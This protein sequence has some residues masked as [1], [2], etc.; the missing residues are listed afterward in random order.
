MTE[1]SVIRSRL[2]R[3]FDAHR[4]VFWHDPDGE[5]AG[6]LDSLG[7]DD[8]QIVRVANDEYAVKY[9]VLRAEP[10]AK[11]LIYR[12]GAALTG[13]GNWLLHLE[14]ACGVFTADP[15]SLVQ[16]HLGFSAADIA[17]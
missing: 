15:A 8:V 14:L 10:E 13:I 12:S 6:D 2:E 7:L 1:P 9:R 11:F 16:Q 4:L 17:N 3:R 5:Y